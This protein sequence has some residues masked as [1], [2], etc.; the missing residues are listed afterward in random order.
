[1]LK[2]VTWTEFGFFIFVFC[3]VFCFGEGFFGHSG[4]MQKFPGQ[5]LNPHH[6]NDHSYGSDNT[7]FLTHWAARVLWMGFYIIIIIICLLFPN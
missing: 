6:Y 7:I 2:D 5:G 3:F 1:M 4:G